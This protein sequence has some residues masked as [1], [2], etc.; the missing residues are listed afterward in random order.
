MLTPSSRAISSASV[1]LPSPG[2]PKNKRVVE[3]FFARDR[4]VDVDPQAVLHLLLPDELGEPL[5][6]KRE[7]DDRLVAQAFGSRDLGS[8]HGSEYIIPGGSS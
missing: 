5:R 4:R 8:G 1:V 7:L 3:R 6:A 2:G